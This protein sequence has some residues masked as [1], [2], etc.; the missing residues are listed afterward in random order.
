[1]RFADDIVFAVFLYQRWVYKVD[2]RRVN[3]FGHRGEGEGDEGDEA[4]GSAAWPTPH[5]KPP[6]ATVTRK[7]AAVTAK[8]VTAK[9]GAPAA[10][11]AADKKKAVTKAKKSKKTQ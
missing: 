8:G 2:M 11:P 3:E 9:E 1:M 10:A 5:T 6:A 4:A 7:T